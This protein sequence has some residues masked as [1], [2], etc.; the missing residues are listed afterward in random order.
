MRFKFH[1]HLTESLGC[2]QS[3]RFH[4]R[5]QRD[6]LRKADSG[7]R[8]NRTGAPHCIPN[9]LSLKEVVDRYSSLAKQGGAPV[10]LSAFGLTPE[11]TA[12]LFTALDEDYHISRFLH[13]SSGAGQ[14]YQIGEEQA[15]H[16]VLDPAISSL[17]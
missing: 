10:A 6:T 15:T 9:M 5:S 8:A 7:R 11:E 17:L 16:L 2:R 4:R 3:T 14:R 1:Q 12:K 13:F